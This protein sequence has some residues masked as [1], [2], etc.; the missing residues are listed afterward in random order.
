V[1]ST[2]G[3]AA[4]EGDLL[5]DPG[6]SMS[7]TAVLVMAVVVLVLLGVWLIAVFRAA[8]QPASGHANPGGQGAAGAAGPQID[9]RGAVA[10]SAQHPD[11]PPG[12]AD[13][14]A[15]PAGKAGSPPAR[16]ARGG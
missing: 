7:L 6:S 8:S 2:R 1:S 9:P 3:L 11:T 13:Q 5:D 14:T 4:K 16:T 15:A 12:Q 10:A